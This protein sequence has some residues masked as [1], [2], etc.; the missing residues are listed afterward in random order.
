MNL[1]KINPDFDFQEFN[2]LT[3]PVDVCLISELPETAIWDW[4]KIPDILS[5][6]Q[7]LKNQR[8]VL[9]GKD[10][11]LLADNVCWKNVPG[12]WVGFIAITGYSTVLFYQQISP[13]LVIED[14]SIAIDWVK[15]GVIAVPALGHVLYDYLRIDSEERG[16]RYDLARASLLEMARE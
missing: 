4:F 2:W 5:P 12:I 10:I 14:G 3:E 6:P 1:F 15:D 16:K 9:S 7:R 8:A 11:N 13:V